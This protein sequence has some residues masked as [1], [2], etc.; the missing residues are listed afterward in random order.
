MAWK[1]QCADWDKRQK[2]AREAGI[3][4]TEGKRPT[5]G[6]VEKA[7]DRPKAPLVV[8]DP[9]EEEDNEWVDEDND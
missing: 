6:V 8:E 2:D 1:E 5:L 9:E 7:E 3:K 4:W